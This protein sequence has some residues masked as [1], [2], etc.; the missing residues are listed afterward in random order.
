M[1]EGSGERKP[2]VMTMTETPNFLNEYTRYAQ[3]LTDAPI[4]FHRF[5]GYSIVSTCLNNRLYFPFG[6]TRI[7]PNMWIILL[8]PSSLYRK[9]TAISIGRRI[10]Q[11]YNKQYIFPDE[12]SQEKILEILSHQSAG[13]F[14]FY[15]FL[16][17][18][19]LLQKDYMAGTKSFLTH[20]YDCPAEYSRLLKGTS[21]NIKQPF[22]N[23][24]SATTLD[25]YLEQ[26]RENDMFGGFLPRFLI[27]PGLTKQ[28]SLALPPVVEPKEF[29]RIR[30][31]LNYFVPYKGA[32]E[33]SEEA[34]KE[35][36]QWHKQ[37]EISFHS[38]D[39]RIQAF[40]VRLCTYII[41]ISMLEAVC[42]SETK[43]SLKSFTSAR[44]VVN[45]ISH[46]L[47]DISEDMEFT[48]SGRNRQKCLKHIK[49]AGN[50]GIQHHW[51]L[52]LTHLSVREM[53]EA[54][55]TLK[56][57]TMVK[58]QY[59]KVSDSQRPQR[60]YFYSNGVLHESNSLPNT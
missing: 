14:C 26:V 59:L 22:I 20:L 54:V 46:Q 51:L 4:D 58:E 17:F 34:K 28:R 3:E 36:I 56:Q 60:R 38:H 15:E 11:D 30:M 23:I 21:Y 31:L 48:K 40:L 8:A 32:I 47:K 10:L 5:V 6:D 41:K 13:L 50:A 35:Y 27:I 29:T 16:S 19:G 52:K 12:F 7:Y 55:D 2:A 57:Q 1:C 42:N 37:F 45:W 33:F 39:K 18:M 43:I 49:D 9:S 53:G 44:Q 25:W 24:L